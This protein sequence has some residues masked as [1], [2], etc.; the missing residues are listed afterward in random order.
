[1]NKEMIPQLQSYAAQN[2]LS[3][4]V[5][6]A[7]ADRERAAARSDI[8]AIFRELEAKKNTELDY[9]EYLDVWK[10]LQKLGAG[11]LVHGRKGNPNRFV[12]SINLRQAGRTALGMKEEAQVEQLKP[13][14]RRSSGPYKPVQPK[15]NSITF[16]IPETV[17]VDDIKALIQL[18]ASISKKV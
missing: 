12:W 7:L 8:D 1:M 13:V 5:F 11:I 15:V 6:K 9:F 17:S 16:V 4:D 18:G 3:K 2:D 14:V 10:E